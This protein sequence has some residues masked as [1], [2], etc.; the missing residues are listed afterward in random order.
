[1]MRTAAGLSGLL[2]D[3]ATAKKRKGKERKGKERKG[4]A[5]NHPL[6]VRTIRG[7]EVTDWRGT[8]PHTAQLLRHNYS[9][10]RIE[11]KLSSFRAAAEIEHVV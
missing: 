7:F 4:K 11:N 1:M 5:P 2:E 3:L 8:F 9:G 6:Q 10:S